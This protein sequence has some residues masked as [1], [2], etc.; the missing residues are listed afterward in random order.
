M[1]GTLIDHLCTN[2]ITSIGDVNPHHGVS[3]SDHAGIVFKLNLSKPKQTLPPGTFLQY[4]KADLTGLCS[5]LHSINWYELLHDKNIND[6]W[7]AFKDLCLE[8]TH[9][10]IPSKKSRRR[11]KKPW[12]TDEIITLARRK[13]RL[14]SKSRKSPDNFTIWETY[15]KCRNKL[16]SLTKREYH[17]YITDIANDSSDHG[18][19][20]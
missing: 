18:K 16:K 5:E 12:I 14:Y 1:D 7:S 17:S 11:E 15:K 10:F 8:C 19:K 9:K 2:N 6:A 20:F 4:S 13:K 3:G